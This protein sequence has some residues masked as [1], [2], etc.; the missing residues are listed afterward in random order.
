MFEAL[1]ELIVDTKEYDE[2]IGTARDRAQKVYAS[3][4][5]ISSSVC[6]SLFA[7]DRM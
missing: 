5:V 3:P 6:V 7:V 2:L 1:V 4:S